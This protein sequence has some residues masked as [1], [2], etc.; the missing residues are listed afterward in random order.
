MR[1]LM[2]H[3]RYQIRGGEDECHEAEQRLLREAGV[4]VDSYDDDNHRV[5]ELG[6][7]RTA[8]ETVWSSGSYR[9]IRERLQAKRYDLVHIHNFFPLISPAVY[10]AAQG[11]GCAVVQ[12]LHNYRLMCPSGI[13]YRD[14]HICEDCLG[15]SV[16]WPGVLHGCYRGSHTGTAAVAAMLTTHRLLGTWQSKVNV[17]VALTEWGRQKYIEGGLPAERIAVKP[18][19]VGQ[20]PGPGDGRG[21]F[22]LFAARL[23]PEKGVDAL[24]E[25]WRRLGRRIPLKIIGDGPLTGQVKQAAQEIEG[26]EYLGRRPLAEFYDLLGQASF[27]VFT[28]TWY[29]GFPRVI[30]ECYARAVPLVAS[31]I[32]PIA[33]VVLDGRTGLQ[34][35]PGDVDDLVAKVGWLLD[36]PDELARMRQEARAEFEAKYTAEVSRRQLLAIYDR[37]IADRQAQE[38]TR[39]GA[40]R[41]VDHAPSSGG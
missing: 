8:V 40:A 26:V 4:E 11:E 23:N 36:H 41:R 33:D 5:D 12:T 15:R 13:F 19:F 6:R 7:W 38:A 16:A 10:Y 29:E 24:L 14:G 34:F 2:V 17:Y 18:N 9:A 28:S 3:C 20:E 27:F 21:G 25:A 39:A 1:V 30:S 31:R 32:G 35:R 22:A 37:A